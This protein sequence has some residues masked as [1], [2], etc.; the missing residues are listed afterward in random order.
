MHLKYL[1][2]A[3]IKKTGYQEEPEQQFNVICL[4]TCERTSSFFS[5]GLPWVCD[6]LIT[7][8][9]IPVSHSLSV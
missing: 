6:E 8:L 7:D 5:Y 9:H 3:K 1:L 2:A 4:F